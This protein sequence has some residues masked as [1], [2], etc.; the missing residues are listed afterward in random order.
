MPVPAGDWRAFAASPD[1]IAVL[2]ARMKEVGVR[3]GQQDRL[4]ARAAADESWRGFAA[5]DAAARLARSLGSGRLLERLYETPNLIPDRYW[6]VKAGDGHDVC[7]RGAVLVRVKGRNNTAAAEELTGELK[8]AME[9][10]PVRPGRELASALWQS[11]PLAAV[12]MLTALAVAAGGTIVE[13]MLF[14]GLFDVTH[15]LGLTGQRVGAITAVLLFG[16]ALL[17][18]EWPVFAVA[19]RLGRQIENRLRVRFLE[20]IPKLGDRYFQSRLTSDMAERSHATKRLRNLPDQVRQL[21][22]AVF[23]LCFTAAA[24]HWL[25][26][27]IAGFVWLIVAIVLVPAFTTQSLLAERDLRVRSHAAGLTRFYLDAMLGPICDSRAWRRAQREAG[28]RD[29]CWANGR[30]RRSVCSVSQWD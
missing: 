12:L 1:F 17:F 22:R 8:A 2:R 4:L 11:G 6:S 28:T 3:R 23:E 29:S 13:A 15:E 14:R 20:K 18:L 26:P 27:A 21:L 10:A 7:V 16:L 24:I 5:L 30:T 9:E 19:G 25:E